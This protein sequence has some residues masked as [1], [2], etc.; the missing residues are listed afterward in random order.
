VGPKGQVVIDREIRERLG[1]EPG[2]EAVQIL[3]PDHVKLFF[4]AP[5]H[6]RSLKGRLEKYVHRRL[7]TEVQWDQARGAAWEE[8]SRGRFGRQ[9]GE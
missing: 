8:A 5:P 1:V 3:A 2:W 9:P 6:R 4:V 7:E